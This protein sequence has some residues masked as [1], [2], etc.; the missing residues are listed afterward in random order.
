MDVLKIFQQ[1]KQEENLSI[2]YLASQLKNTQSR[3]R[4]SDLVGKI[5]KQF[6]C[7]L[8]RETFFKLNIPKILFDIALQPQ[9]DTNIFDQCANLLKLV[10]QETPHQAQSLLQIIV[11]SFHKPKYTEQIKFF[12]L[13]GQIC[14]SSGSAQSIIDST[15]GVLIIKFYRSLIKGEN[16]NC[17]VTDAMS[18]QDYVDHD[19]VMD[20]EKSSQSQ[21]S[22]LSLDEDLI[23]TKKKGGAESP[24]S[25]RSMLSEFAK[26]IYGDDIIQQPN[27]RSNYVAADSRQ[28]SQMDPYD[29]KEEFSQDQ[30]SQDNDNEDSQDNIIHFSQSKDDLKNGEHT[31]QIKQL[32]NLPTRI[33]DNKQHKYDLGMDEEYNTNIRTSQILNQQLNSGAK[34]KVV[35]PLNLSTT[36]NSTTDT[37]IGS[38]SHNQNTQLL[39]SDLISSQEED[40]SEQNFDT[41]EIVVQKEKLMKAGPMTQYIQK[42]TKRPKFVPKLNL[43]KLKE[44]QFEF[45]GEPQVNRIFDNEVSQKVI[46]PLIATHAKVADQMFQDKVNQIAKAKKG[47]TLLQEVGNLIGQYTA[48]SDYP[49]ITSQKKVKQEIISEVL[50]MTTKPQIPNLDLFYENARELPDQQFEFNELIKLSSVINKLQIGNQQRI[51][52]MYIFHQLLVNT[53]QQCVELFHDSIQVLIYD[54]LQ[55][56]SKKSG[57]CSAVISSSMAFL[58]ELNSISYPYFHDEWNSA[59][60]KMYQYIDTPFRFWDEVSRK[61]VTQEKDGMKL[62]ERRTVVLPNQFNLLQRLEGLRRSFLSEI[63]LLCEKLK[64]LCK[65]YQNLSAIE[66]IPVILG[67]LSDIVKSASDSN[68]MKV[69]VI[70]YGLVSFLKLLDLLVSKKIKSRQYYVFISHR[71]LQLFNALI[72]SSGNAIDL[73]TG[74]MNNIFISIFALQEISVNQWLKRYAYLILMNSRVKIE[75]SG[76]FINQQQCDQTFDSMR[77]TFFN[78]TKNF[79]IQLKQQLFKCNYN[80]PRE[81]FQFKN[82]QLQQLTIAK[83]SNLIEQNSPLGID[84]NFELQYNLNILPLHQM[85]NYQVNDQEMFQLQNKTVFQ[86]QHN[87]ISDKTV[88]NNF[89]LDLSDNTYL[90]DYDVGVLMQF[91]FLNQAQVLESNT[92]RDIYVAC[93]EALQ[94]Y[95]SIPG[96]LELINKTQIN[97][98]VVYHY[99]SFLKFYN[100]SIL[101]LNKGYTISNFTLAR[102][103]LQ[104]LNAFS[105]TEDE[106]VRQHIFIIKIVDFLTQQLQFEASLTKEEAKNIQLKYNLQDDIISENI[107]ATMYN[108]ADSLGEL[109]LEN[110]TNLQKPKNDDLKKSVN[111]TNNT[112]NNTVSELNNTPKIFNKLSNKS[113]NLKIDVVSTKSIEP[114]Q[115]VMSPTIFN[116]NNAWT[117]GS[118]VIS[119]RMLNDKENSNQVQTF[120]E[121]VKKQ[122][123]ES[124]DSDSD[125][126]GKT[127]TRLGIDLKVTSQV[128][129]VVDLRIDTPQLQQLPLSNLSLVKTQQKVN[130]SIESANK[131]Q[132]SQTLSS[133]SSDSESSDIPVPVKKVIPKP[134]LQLNLNSA[135]PKLQITEKKVDENILQKS[136]G[137]LNIDLKSKENMKAATVDI[138]MK[139]HLVVG[140]QNSAKTQAKTQAISGIPAIPIY[141]DIELHQTIILFIMQLIIKPQT[142]TFDQNYVTQFPSNSNMQNIL[143]IL[144]EHLNSP[145]NKKVLQSLLQKKL[146]TSQERL[147]R[148]L[149]YQKFNSE[150]YKLQQYKLLAKGAFGEVYSGNVS[151]ARSQQLQKCATPVAIK[152]QRLSQNINDRCVL[153]D[154]FNEIT[155]MEKLQ[156]YQNFCQIY[157]YGVTPEGYI[158]VMQKYHTSFRNFRYQLFK[159]QSII[160]Y[161]KNQ[162]K[163]LPLYGHEE[164]LMRFVR[165]FLMAYIL[166]LEELS[167]M[168]QQNIIHFD[169]KADNIFINPATIQWLS[170]NNIPALDETGEFQYE[171]LNHFKNIKHQ[172]QLPFTI[173]I[174]DFGE[175]HIFCSEEDKYSQLS[176][177]T[178]FNKSPEM[179][180]SANQQS[181]FKRGQAKGAGPL[182]D[183]WSAGCTLYEMLTNDFLFYDADWIRFFLRVSAINTK[184]EFAKDSFTFADVP[185]LAQCVR[186]IRLIPEKRA[187]LGNCQPLIDLIEFQLVQDPA[188]RPSVQQCIDMTK[189]VL[190]YYFPPS[191]QFDPSDPSPQQQNLPGCV[192]AGNGWNFEIIGS[193]EECM[194]N[195]NDILT[196]QV[197]ITNLDANVKGTKLSP[198]RSQQSTHPSDVFQN[199]FLLLGSVNDLANRQ[200]VN[201]MNIQTVVD[202]TIQT[203]AQTTYINRVYRPNGKLLQL[204]KINYSKVNKEQFKDIIISLEQIFDAV[205]CTRALN[206]CVFFADETGSGLAANLVLACLMEFESMYLYQSAVYLKRIRPSIVLNPNFMELLLIWHDKRTKIGIKLMNMFSQK[207]NDRILMEDPEIYNFATIRI[208]KANYRCI[209]GRTF[210]V[211]KPT[212]HF[213]YVLCNCVC[214]DEYGKTSHN[215]EATDCPTTSCRTL[216]N[217]YT[218]IYGLK[219]YKMLYLYSVDTDFISNWARST[220]Q[221]ALIETFPNAENK[222]LQFRAV[223]ET[224]AP[225]YRIQNKDGWRLNYCVLCGAPTHYMRQKKNKNEMCVIA[226]FSN[227]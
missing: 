156:K 50:F 183:V 133:D 54:I 171:L 70:E 17:Q 110:E 27:H 28:L 108:P 48:M 62:I 49:Y 37:G 159:K 225:L 81:I 145:I 76:L 74:N 168:H 57:F 227:K 107:E 25:A 65:C 72:D 154:L 61:Y 130:I 1:T 127:A 157:D 140:Q 102:H 38:S 186:G 15:C 211:L 56:R 51:G 142:G 90:S 135:I 163:A 223:D 26:T 93:L 190:K 91:M 71:I 160:P 75:L 124:T 143:Y 100:S 36:Y 209:C 103:H 136:L 151:L 7:N 63:K 152:V 198:I 116:L 8:D 82:D 184:V 181:K 158:M 214:S 207:L 69:A 172:S 2:Q 175:S 203:R 131:T 18:Y 182:S 89:K 118:T 180:I 33:P 67:T 84:D 120:K 128:P 192:F 105:Q 109:N 60:T 32:L 13:I 165:I 132:T 144:H 200:F 170:L 104:I 43:S 188:N 196:P 122:E 80:A 34:D 41:E 94:N 177:G 52:C 189:C 73:Q 153:Y 30:F 112:N 83:M 98:Y 96:V 68:Y 220:Q 176:K 166:F 219:M 86:K 31:I 47:Q 113:N 187:M 115:Q 85:L 53:S 66:D 149:C 111:N 46:S 155:V 167:L 201:S 40:G 129:S 185:Q 193:L 9:I 138:N 221:V 137:K 217:Y 204:A 24:A 205:R 78:F 147:F 87:T 42:I 44:I 222:Q 58:S 3:D 39:A 95:I 99:I 141:Y 216:Q 224:R 6:L 212:A 14:N 16:F 101:S 59:M 106:S 213:Q 11:T 199:G 125:G 19:E 218:S 126:W 10:L 210:F 23:H 88:K 55:Q 77:Q 22:S 117:D 5:S 92:G 146:D 161:C 197:M 121:Q 139:L 21:M 134:M 208:A 169:L 97:K 150:L 29:G 215:N 79:A 123:P 179:L 45:G 174:A 35:F 64:S 162:Q 4:I 202:C 12:L 164:S 178:E 20:D 191:Y 194:G 148:L 119:P 226:N 173:S 114:Y 195:P 206:G